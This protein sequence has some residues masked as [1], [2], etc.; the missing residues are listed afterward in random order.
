MSDEVF[1]S[2]YLGTTKGNLSAG[3]GDLAINIIHGWISDEGD[4]NLYTLGHRRTVLSP[5]LKETGF[6]L[7]YADNSAKYSVYTAMSVHDVDAGGDS[8]GVA[9]PAQTMP[10]EYFK[11]DNITYSAGDIYH[12]EISGK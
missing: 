10:V 5:V 7:V 9:W 12:V 4:N 11:P 2:A 6:G 8:F 3:I 1:A